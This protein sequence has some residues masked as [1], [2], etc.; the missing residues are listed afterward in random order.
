MK[1]AFASY[2][3]YWLDVFHS[4]SHTHEELDALVEGE[5]Y[6][7]VEAALAR[8][9]GVLIAVPHIGNWDVGGAW[10]ASKGV[11]LTV[12][13]EELEP[14]ELFRWF[15]SFRSSVGLKVVVNGP[16]VGSELLAA[17]HRNEAIALLCDRDVDGTGGNYEFF[18]EVT[19][20]PKGPATLAF[21]S[22]ATLLPTVVYEHGEG[23]KVV[24]EEPVQ[25]EREGRLSEDVDRVT[26][27]L[28][29]RLETMIRR[30]PEQWHVFQPNWP[31][32]PG[33]RRLCGS[34]KCARIA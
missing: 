32:D 31:T 20:I 33:A 1:A 10:F 24:F 23:Y 8:G 4:L 18:G 11:P 16:K 9:K 34:R 15:A 14:P 30:A 7:R 17:L 12:V 26:G 6:E 3:R 19:K 5:H 27:E 22:G 2:A 21:R 13:V 28:I 25:V 29:R